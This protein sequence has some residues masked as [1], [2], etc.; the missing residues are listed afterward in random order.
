MKCSVKLFRLKIVRLALK[1]HR[2]KHFIV[3]NQMCTCLFFY[4][5]G[6]MYMF[7]LKCLGRNGAKACNSCRSLQELSNEYLN[8]FN[9]KTCAK[10]FFNSQIRLPSHFRENVI[11]KYGVLLGSSR[12]LKTVFQTFVL[13][14]SW[15]RPLDQ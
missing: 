4:I 5:E 15:G 7:L 8:N 14:F 1:Q 12:C 3:P 10:T 13:Y 9:A 11:S 6:V 2:S